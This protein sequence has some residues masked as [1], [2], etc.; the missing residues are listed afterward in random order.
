MNFDPLVV[1]HLGEPVEVV[2]RYLDSW[3]EKGELYCGNAKTLI[4][5]LVGFVISHNS[6]QP[7]FPGKE[8]GARANVSGVPR[9]CV[10][11]ARGTT[12]G[13][14]LARLAFA[15]IAGLSGPWSWH[16][17]ASQDE[18]SARALAA[19]GGGG[20]LD[21]S[22]SCD[23][24]AKGSRTGLELQDKDLQYWPKSRSLMDA[25]DIIFRAP[26]GVNPHGARTRDAAVIEEAKLVKAAVADARDCG[27][28]LQI[29][30]LGVE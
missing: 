5:E 26:A 8:L 14:E 3:I 29:C 25:A 28:A 20:T 18:W 17:L 2:A 4:L 22:L 21:S 16:A 10:S 24:I 6:L 13:R 11:R 15:R 9:R 12:R 23:L 30:I 1:R 27:A 7:V 19:T